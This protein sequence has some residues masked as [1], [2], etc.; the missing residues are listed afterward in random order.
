MVFDAVPVDNFDRRGNYLF[1]R[2]LPQ[3]A[4]IETLGLQSA[5]T[6]VDWSVEHPITQSVAFDN[7]LIKE[8]LVVRPKG[9]GETLLESDQTP[10]IYTWESEKGQ[11]GRVVFIGFDLFDSD[12]RAQA[13]FPILMQN[14][15][16]WLTARITSS[17]I[18]PVA[19]DNPDNPLHS[20]ESN[21]ASSPIP[22]S[23]EV[24][25]QSY[26]HT[27]PIWSWLVLIALIILI[28]ECFL[29]G[30]IRLSSR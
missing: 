15:V 13:E 29:L 22:P 9:K 12:L 27:V 30:I 24:K 5:P 6:P 7:T 11:E 19:S 18:Y 20:R 1:I 26:T 17:V 10:L 3:E 16:E 21:L 28:I 14:T 4:P 2:S 8:A 25:T 23:T